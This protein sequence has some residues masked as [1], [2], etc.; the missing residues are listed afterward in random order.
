[1]LWTRESPD[2]A[3]NLAAIVSGTGAGA[4][5]G[6]SSNA[7]GSASGGATE[8][9][10][11][12]IGLALWQLAHTRAWRAILQVAVRQLLTPNHPVHAEMNVGTH[13]TFLLECPAFTGPA[14]FAALEA[15]APFGATAASIIRLQQD[16]DM[17]VFSSRLCGILCEHTGFSGHQKSGNL[18]NMNLGTGALFPEPEPQI[19]L[20]LAAERPRWSE[21]L[22]LKKLHAEVRAGHLLVDGLA[23]LAGHAIDMHAPD[24]KLDRWETMLGKVKYNK[25]NV[26]GDA[27]QL[28]RWPI[29]GALVHGIGGVDRF[30]VTLPSKGLREDRY[31]RSIRD[32]DLHRILMD[33]DSSR[34][35]SVR[36]EPLI[37]PGK[38]DGNGDIV[39]GGVQ[40]LGAQLD[41][42]MQLTLPAA[43]QLVVNECA[44]ALHALR[45][46]PPKVATALNVSRAL[47][48][49]AL[50]R[51]DVEAFSRLDDPSGTGLRAHFWQHRRP[52]FLVRQRCPDSVLARLP[53]DLFELMLK[54]CIG[55]GFAAA[56]YAW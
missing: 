18:L 35:D 10:L 26:H 44:L 23:A 30:H 39:G 25:P 37:A 2:A 45:V 17:S 31:L 1:M 53:L 13:G 51:T 36:E 42:H 22:P 40:K 49:L 38:R 33:K 21:G 20:K 50:P 29:C 19:L 9:Q 27:F 24:T 12:E 15:I 7:G 54:E 34:Y 5:A 6:S 46:T 32:H 55:T 47:V 14:E 28:L 41:E 3:S 43:G 16:S 52:F 4:T 8:A 11:Q 56:L 48:E